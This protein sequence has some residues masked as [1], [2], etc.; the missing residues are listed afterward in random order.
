[1]TTAEAMA[2]RAWVVFWARWC[3]AQPAENAV[4][5][6]LECVRLQTQFKA[7]CVLDGL[8]RTARHPRE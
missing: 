5:A 7:S 1:M 8:R 4:W 6:E 3:H 2:P